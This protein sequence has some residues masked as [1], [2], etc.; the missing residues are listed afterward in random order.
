M[1]EADA[2]LQHLEAQAR[3]LDTQP[4]EMGR[5]LNELSR[6]SQDYLEAVPNAPAFMAGD[7]VGALKPTLPAQGSDLSEV[8][9]E[10]DQGVLQHGIAPTSGRFMGYVPGGGL[11]SAAVGDF[12]A[13]LTNRYAGVY[14]ASPGAAQVENL[15]V[16]W[17]RDI[18][19]FGDKAWGTLQSGGSLA[20][21]T[22]MV[23]ARESRPPARW[24]KGVVYTTD[25][26]HICVAKALRTVG[27]G[28]ITSRATPVDAQ[29]RMRTDVLARQI[30]EDAAAGLE[31]WIAVVSAGTVNTGAVD[32]IGDVAA[33]CRTHGMWLHVD[34]AYGGFFILTSAGKKKLCALSEA[35]SVVLD[36]HKGLF[37]PYGC[38]AT[39]VSDASTLRRAFAYEADY[40]AD[41][42]A[43]E[44]ASP[45]D[46][47][48]ELT[49]HFRGL[50]LWIS[51]K[52]HGLER[53]VAAL[54]EKLALAQM[55]YEILEETPEVEMGP[56][57]QL[58]CV[59]FRAV[60]DDARTETVLNTILQSGRVH[61]SS[62]KLG[63]KM[64]LRMCILCLRT[65]RAEV[66]TALREVKG[67]L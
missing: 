58:S 9:R 24:S 4:A 27:L 63:G 37:L 60:G 51:L 56:A 43:P 8:L 7:S 66:M 52:L 62:T 38:G 45:A 57:P 14:L 67:C 33:L 21:V 39:L 1:S 35:D 50:R 22:A 29:F 30:A 40:M 49:R 28:H 47:S 12:L 31:P 46:F 53:F 16:G 36:P 42:H 26:A 11:P 44:V 41:V 18:I 13:A 55:A 19:G 23:A 2:Q 34:A 64:Y 65:H 32:P 17:L 5:W 61:L 54:E 15:A 20:T 6:F 25:E 59:T 48:P 10:F 3:Q